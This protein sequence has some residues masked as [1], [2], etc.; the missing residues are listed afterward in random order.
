VLAGGV[1]D[2]ELADLFAALVVHP[3][4]TVA[5]EF[6]ADDPIDPWR[7][8]IRAHGLE[9]YWMCYGKTPEHAVF[10]ARVYRHESA[11]L[12]PTDFG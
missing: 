5:L 6:V 12:E 11:G 4:D 2:D 1:T 7:V 10:Q 3:D 8:T 9:T